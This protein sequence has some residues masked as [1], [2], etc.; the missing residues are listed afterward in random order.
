[1]N[2]NID[3][4]SKEAGKNLEFKKNISMKPYPIGE[5]FENLISSISYYLIKRQD[6][7]IEPKYTEIYDLNEKL[8]KIKD[9][10]SLNREGLSPN[11]TFF[12]YSKYSMNILDKDTEKNII[13]ILKNNFSIQTL[14]DL[15]DKNIFIT[16]PMVD[17]AIKNNQLN[18]L[19]L[20]KILPFYDYKDLYFDYILNQDKFNDLLTSTFSDDSPFLP[21]HKIPSNPF[22]ENTKYKNDFFEVF[23]MMTENAKVSKM[24]SEQLN[25]YLIQNMNMM[26]IF[27][28]NFLDD[29]KIKEINSKFKKIKL[30][31]LHWK[32][33]YEL[34]KIYQSMVDKHNHLVNKDAI[35]E[36]KSSKLS[37]ELEYQKNEKYILGISDKI[38]VVNQYELSVEDKFYV[39][40]LNQELDILMT[41]YEKVQEKEQAKELLNQCIQHIHEGLQNI[42]DKHQNKIVN[43]LT[44]QE[45]YLN[46]MK[47]RMRH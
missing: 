24:S 22:L 36:L 26:E 13:K 1:M 7:D 45:D 8:K 38:K 31:D 17:I 27:E 42:I 11:H 47:E 37:N 20:K 25:N 4:N 23:K 34:P 40:K 3:E 43:N 18:E 39:K 21:S 16:P 19:L 33:R 14:K 28:K 35:I 5:A 46:G 10:G 29:V 44:V 12:N 9:F 15:S 32:L 2:E 41:D 30:Q 6:K